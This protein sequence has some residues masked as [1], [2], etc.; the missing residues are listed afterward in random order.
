MTSDGVALR[1]LPESPQER[2]R[3]THTGRRARGADPQSQRLRFA[4]HQQ[5]DANGLVDVEL[6]AQVGVER[7][8]AAVRIAA[9]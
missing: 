7:Q 1:P 4:V 3:E 6:N 5:L 9:S 2:E 8:A